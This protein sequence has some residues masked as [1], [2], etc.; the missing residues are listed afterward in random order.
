M[1]DVAS[2]VQQIL[3][4]V[5][6]G[7]TWVLPVSDE[8]GR[9]VDFRIAAAGGQGRDIYGRGVARVDGRLSELYPSMVDGPLWRLYQ[10]VL[11]SGESGQLSDFRYEEKRSGVV[12]DSLFDVSV[13][14]VL[15]GLLVW[16]QRLD[17]DRLRLDRTELLGRLGW[18]EYDLAT[19]R[20]DWSPGMYRIFER[21][22]ALVPC[23]G[24][25][26][27]RP[28]WP[29]TAGSPKLCGRRWTAGPRRK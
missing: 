28:C 17:E 20:S 27:P 22:P 3:S 23:P 7:C 25:S 29:M 13:H 11:A 6:G 8:S 24:P 18:A 14:P 4:V 10:K 5:P 9:V 16:W 21:D 26:W 1:A 19:G 2:V 15:G 12:A